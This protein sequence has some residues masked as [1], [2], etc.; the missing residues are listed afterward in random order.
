M[1]SILIDV[2]N[3][4]I[5]EVDYSGD[6]QDIYKLIECSCFTIATVDDKNVLYVDDEGLLNNPKHFFKYEGYHQPLAG[7]CLIL[8]DNGMGESADTTLTVQEVED[9]VTF[10]EHDTVP[11]VDTNWYI[12]E[13]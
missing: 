13:F 4:E 12:V 9:K 11:E 6:F 7:N 3:K 5:R 8:G 10:I 1:K 2:F